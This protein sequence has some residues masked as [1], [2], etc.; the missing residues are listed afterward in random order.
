[1]DLN[2]AAITPKVLSR[3]ILS[4]AILR[5]TFRPVLVHA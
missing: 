1:M 3:E 5:F 4:N 2:L